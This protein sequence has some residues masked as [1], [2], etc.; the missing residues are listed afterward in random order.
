MYRTTVHMLIILDAVI[1]PTF[2]LILIFD[3]PSIVFNSVITHE[4]AMVKAGR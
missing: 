2:R 3:T 1:G 4:S